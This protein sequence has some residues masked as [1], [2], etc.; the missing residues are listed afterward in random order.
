MLTVD[1]IEKFSEYSNFKDLEDFNET[2]RNFL[3]LHKEDFTKS[4]LVAFKRLVR[5]SAKVV[6]VSNVSINTLLAAI[7]LKDFSFGV[8]E[9]TFHRMKRKAIKLGILEVKEVFRKNESQ[10][11]NLW[12]FKRFDG[13]NFTTEKKNDTPKEKQKPLET[14]SAKESI[15]SQS[16]PLKT[17]TFKK[18]K[19]LKDINKRIGA[20]PTGSDKVTA[21]AV[22]FKDL[23][24]TYTADYVPKAFVTTVKPFFDNAKTIEEFWRMARIDTFRVK[25]TVL[26]SETVLHTAIHAFKQMIGKLKKG[27]VKNPVAYFKG[28]LKQ[29]IDRKV[30][31]AIREE[32]EALQQQQDS[33]SHYQL[34]GQPYFYN[35]LEERD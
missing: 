3:T 16:T 13:I 7:K 8:S 21:S 30:V 14:A 33:P 25:G 12:V 11:S 29:M 10:S 2:I 23:D 4:E 32:L 20:S 6:G 19:T 1:K 9:S 18:T 17:R 27:L 34:A 35:W 22:A 15:V 26:D 5:Y 28:V 31:T 24:H